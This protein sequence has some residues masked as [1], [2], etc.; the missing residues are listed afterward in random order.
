MERKASGAS[1]SGNN[2]STNGRTNA[3]VPIVGCVE[4]Q[5]GI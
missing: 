4:S 2:V 5:Y 1:L 3:K